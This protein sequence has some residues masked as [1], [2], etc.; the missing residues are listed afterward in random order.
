MACK[1]PF[2]FPYKEAKNVFLISGIAVAV[3]I[4]SLLGMITFVYSTTIKNKKKFILVQIIFLVLDGIVWLLKNGFSAL[5][6][7]VVGII[8]NLFIYFNKQTKILDIIFIVTAVALGLIVINWKDFKFYELLPIIANLEFS[9]VLL[10]AKDIKYIKCGLII[11]SLLWATYALFTG[12]YI[13][14]A[15]NTISFIT[16]IISLILILK[17]E[18]NNKKVDIEIE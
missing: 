2:Y 10:K 4:I 15:F 16:T 13:T 11:S 3:E 7:N 8:R 12:V 14:F 18:K 5:I 17:K 1:E 6:Q 9:I